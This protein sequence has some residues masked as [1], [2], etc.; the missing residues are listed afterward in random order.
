MVALLKQYYDSPYFVLLTVKNPASFF[1]GVAV[2]A[3]IMGCYYG[4]NYKNRK[5]KFEQEA[6]R[7]GE[8]YQ[9]TRQST[10]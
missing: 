7:H 8:R 1:G 10:K 5:A 2:G 6:A 4:R 3:T 9:H